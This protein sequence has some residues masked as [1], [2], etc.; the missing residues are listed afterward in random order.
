MEDGE[1]RKKEDLLDLYPQA[2]FYNPVGGD[3]EV[4]GSGEHV[5]G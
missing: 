4:G 1:N 3:V 2:Y 5:L